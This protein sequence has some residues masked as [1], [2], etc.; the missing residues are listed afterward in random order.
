MLAFEVAT[1]VSGI[2]SLATTKK[3][4]VGGG[5][6]PLTLYLLSN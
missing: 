4:C 2:Y 3:M 1:V 6:A 5:E